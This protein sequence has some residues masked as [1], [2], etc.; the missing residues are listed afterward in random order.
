MDARHA[1]RMIEQLASE[2][3]TERHQAFRVMREQ[4]DSALSYLIDGARHHSNWRVQAG[5]MA[6]LAARRAP[7]AESR[8][9]LDAIYPAA[10][11]SAFVSAWE[12]T[13]S[14]K[15]R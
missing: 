8:R 5:C 7:P 10:P 3:W 11:K 2:S 1:R 4:G 15:P 9:R 6:V 12:S 14:R 13:P